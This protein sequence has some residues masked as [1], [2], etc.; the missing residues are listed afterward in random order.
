MYHSYQASY[1]AIAQATFNR[2]SG[3]C[4]RHDVWKDAHERWVT[5][6]KISPNGT[7]IVSGAMDSMVKVWD[8]NSGSWLQYLRGHSSAVSSVSFPTDR[9][10]VSGSR[11]G[12]SKVWDTE[13][14]SCRCTF[15]HAGERQW[16]NAVEAWSVSASAEASKSPVTLGRQVGGARDIQNANKSFSLFGNPGGGIGNMSTSSSPSAL[17]VATGTSK[18]LL[19]VWDERIPSRPAIV[20]QDSPQ[21]GVLP[22]T[23]MGSIYCV[24]AHSGACLAAGAASGNICGDEH[25][26]LFDL[27]KDTPLQTLQAHSTAVTCMVS[28]SRMLISGSLGGSVLVH[29]I[30][31]E[32]CEVLGSNLEFLGGYSHEEWVRSVDEVDGCVVSCCKRG[33]IKLSCLKAG[34]VSNDPVDAGGLEIVDTAW[35]LSHEAK[36]P[37][38]GMNS[39]LCVD[40]AHSVAVDASGVVAGCQDKSVQLFWFSKNGKALIFA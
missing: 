17:L 10:V 32:T 19:G 24:S 20:L 15:I 31:G 3:L 7:R 40:H 21:P 8:R 25:R 1:S 33:E 6:V 12:T 34:E 5:S 39:D 11:D 37:G 35:S 18:G 29:G 4:T 14:G 38:S 22:P 27:R 30:R 13:T 23:I 16:V 26:Y 28:R 36:D 2:L 9:T